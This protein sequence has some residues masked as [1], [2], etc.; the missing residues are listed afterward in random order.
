HSALRMMASD[1]HREALLFILSFAGQFGLFALMWWMAGRWAFSGRFDSGWFAGWALIL[2]TMVPLQI[3]NAERMNRLSVGFG[4]LFRERMLQGALHLDFSDVRGQGLGQLLGRVLESESFD[5]AIFGGIVWL[6][7]GAFEVLFAVLILSATGSSTL[8]ISF[9]AW[10]GIVVALCWYRFVALRRLTSG[11][12]LRLTQDMIEA[13]VGSRTQKVQR[14]ISDFVDENDR[15][16]AAYHRACASLDRRS[17]LI[18]VVL[19]RGWF[20]LAILAMAPGY[21]S[22]VYSITQLALGFGGILLANQAIGS[23]TQALLRLS[24]ARIGWRQVQPLLEAARTEALR[25]HPFGAGAIANRGGANLPATLM[26]ARGLQFRHAGRARSSVRGVS[27]RIIEGERWIISGASGCGKSTL[28]SLFAGLR[29]PTSGLLTFSGMDRQSIGRDHW[30]RFVSLA[31]QFQEN[32]VFSECFA[33][34]LLMGRRWPADSQDLQEATDVCRELGLGALLAKMPAGLFQHLGETG[35][36][37]S[38]GERSRLFLARAILSEAPLVILDES[39]G[40]LDP[41]TYLDA[42]ECAKKRAPALIVV[43]HE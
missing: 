4:V 30:R 12:R 35:W 19:P 17:V 16:L 11:P 34:N 37:L 20:I 2:A 43:A 1:L 7:T 42:L 28:A 18:E 13:M 3:F 39:F 9:C 24:E 29:E 14:A 10:L 26:E 31:P 21:A 40:P 23:I 36:Q 22:S 38:H 27:L 6:G 41:E 32:H 33:F 25:P 5:R 15:S 8:L